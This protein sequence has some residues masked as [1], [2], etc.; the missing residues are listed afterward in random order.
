MLMTLEKLSID[1]TEQLER[2]AG[3]VKEEKVSTEKSLL[4]DKYPRI[5]I[6]L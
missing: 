5:F 4:A 1:I 3:E 2:V 6:I